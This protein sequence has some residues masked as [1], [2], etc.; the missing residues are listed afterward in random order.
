MDS[1]KIVLCWID[2]LFMNK[3]QTPNAFGFYKSSVR[4][5][6]IDW[7]EEHYPDF[8]LDPEGPKRSIGKHVIRGSSWFHA[9]GKSRSA[10]RFQ[11][12]PMER[13][14]FLGFRLVREHLTAFPLF[15]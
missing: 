14:D 15:K 5:W 10:A 6:A 7:Y 8:Q 9:L 1:L 12:L 3:D 13:F 11:A 2:G 4:E